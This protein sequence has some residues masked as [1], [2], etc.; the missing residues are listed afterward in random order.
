MPTTVITKQ[1]V[2]LIAQVEKLLII[3]LEDQN[4]RCAPAIRATEKEGGPTLKEFWKGSNIYQAVMNI[5]EARNEV[6]Q[7]NLNGVWRKLCPDI[8]SDFHGF[9]DTIEEVTNT[10][11]EMGKELNF[12]IAPEDVNELRASH[13]EELTNEDLIDLEQ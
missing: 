13:S 6:K 1:R 2:G 12:D 9:T 11:A 5:G 8:V 3:W 4:Q 7:S 10:L